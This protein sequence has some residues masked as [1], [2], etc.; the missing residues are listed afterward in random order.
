VYSR[1]LSALAL[2]PLATLAI[3]DSY[4]GAR[5]ARAADVPVAVTRSVYFADEMVEGVVAVGPGLH[6]RHGW[7]PVPAA[8]PAD[9][10]VTLDDL[11][12]WHARMELVSHYG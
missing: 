12:D 3:E 8:V 2:G 9:G 7:R 5:A 11:I 10:R 1:A 6:T 4:G